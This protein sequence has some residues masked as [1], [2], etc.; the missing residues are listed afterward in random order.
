MNNYMHELQEKEKISFIFLDDKSL[1]MILFL[2][3]NTEE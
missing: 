1:M 2:K 3:R